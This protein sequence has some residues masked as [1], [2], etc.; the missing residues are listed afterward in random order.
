MNKKY[1]AGV[2][3]FVLVAL[4]VLGGAWLY[5]AHK[6]EADVRGK[7]TFARTK[8]KIN[9]LG[10]IKISAPESGE[11]NIIR[12][13]DGSWRF[14][15]A[16]EYYVNEDMLSSF[17]NM[18]RSSVIISSVPANEEFLA[19]NNLTEEKGIRL[20]TYDYD[21]NL[22]DEVLF[23]VHDAE[24]DLF[25][26]KR[27]DASVYVYA[28]SSVSGV[29]ASA[30]DW[31]PYPLLSIKTPEIKSVT[32]NGEK[33]EF[34]E[35]KRRL[36]RS[37]V[38]RD[39]ARTLEFLNYYGLT[40]KSDL[41]DLPKDTQVRQIDVGMLNGMIYKLTVLNVDGSYW[42]VISMDANKVFTADAI[43]VAANAYR[44]YSD[45]VFRLSDEQGNVLFDEQLFE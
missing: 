5:N 11:I 12:L 20:K 33:T 21:G 2:V 28:V 34:N 19:K 25:W 1:V 8:D 3:L 27:N 39:L 41:V 18:I 14:K 7:Y 44:Y 37:S 10:N 29:S 23:G 35:F 24:H 38:W 16:K 13:Q 22:L 45:W 15:E 40:F 43:N 36:Q 26:I 6:H 42:I 30:Q 9:Y 32:I 31:L 17:F 4:S